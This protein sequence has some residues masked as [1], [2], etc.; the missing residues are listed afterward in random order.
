MKHVHRCVK[1]CS[2]LLPHLAARALTAI[3]VA[4]GAGLMFG[5]GAPGVI[6][7]AHAQ[8]YPSKPVRILAS[9]GGSDLV[10][11]PDYS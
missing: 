8:H 10:A 4:V 3:A 2:R 11:S 6:D 9:S 5:A 1:V 7:Q